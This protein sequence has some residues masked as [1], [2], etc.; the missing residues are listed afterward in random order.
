M[1]QTARFALPF[2]AAGQVRKELQ[3]NESLQRIDLLLHALVE[4]PP[5]NDPPAGPVAGQSYLV[6]DEPTGAWSGN[7]GSI[8][9]FTEGGWRFLAPPEGAQL[10]LRT[11]GETMVRRNGAWE[12]GI[13]RAREIRVDGQRVLGTRQPPIDAPAGGSTVDEEARIALATVIAA[14]RAHGLIESPI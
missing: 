6:G 11:T 10:L 7:A 13:V 1:D 8:A 4:G 14:L 12:T 2:L 9:G 5:G 3:V